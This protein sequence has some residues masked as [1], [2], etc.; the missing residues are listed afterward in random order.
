MGSA[1]EPGAGAT[2]DGA[3]RAPSGCWRRRS[4]KAPPWGAAAA[5]GAGKA[6]WRRR[7]AIG[8]EAPAD[9]C[10]VVFQGQAVSSAGGDP[11]RVG[12]RHRDVCCRSR[13]PTTAP[14]EAGTRCPAG[15]RRQPAA[16]IDPEANLPPSSRGRRS[17][18]RHE[19][20][21]VVAQAHQVPSVA[22]YEAASISVRACF[23]FNSSLTQ[24]SFQGVIVR[25]CS[26][27]KGGL[28]VRG[29]ARRAGEA[30]RPVRGCRLESWCGEAR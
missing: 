4:A 8:I 28:R 2:A 18:H 16:P 7:L 6:R 9:D 10:A 25:Q 1:V 24:G 14:P 13:R 30:A 12:E 21:H 15:D 27:G 22:L 29:G 5:G 23:I 20:V 26:P 19:A 3:L 11:D 17:L